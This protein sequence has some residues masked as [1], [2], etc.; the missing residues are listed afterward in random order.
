MRTDAYPTITATLLEQKLLLKIL[1]QN[2]RRLAASFKPERH[3]SEN[4]YTPS[5]LLP[6]RV[7]SMESIGSLTKSGCSRCGVP[8]VSR[9]SAC[10]SAAY[11]G[12]G[13]VYTTIMKEFV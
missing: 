5:F 10:Q 1:E 12:K 4:S 7:L 8:A 3:F 2:S 9:C 6:L 11:C 13:K